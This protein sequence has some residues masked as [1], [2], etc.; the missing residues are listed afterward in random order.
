V[1]SRISYLT[2]SKFHHSLKQLGVSL[3]LRLTTA[4]YAVVFELRSQ[5]LKVSGQNLV[6]KT[7]EIEDCPFLLERWS[8][9][10][11]TSVVEG[12]AELA[13][14]APKFEISRLRLYEKENQIA[15]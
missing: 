10:V 15:A 13:F 5:L 2:R 11:V 4:W 9:F 14:I 12:I 3:D 6:G 7:V 1:A 8:P